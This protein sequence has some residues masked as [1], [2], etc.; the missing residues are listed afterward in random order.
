MYLQTE[1]SI[2]ATSSCLKICNTF[3]LSGTII[4]DYRTIILIT[5]SEMINQTTFG[6]SG[7]QR[8]V[9]TDPSTHCGWGTFTKDNIHHNYQGDGYN[10]FHSEINRIKFHVIWLVSVFTTKAYALLQQ[11]TICELSIIN[12][13]CSFFNFHQR[14]YLHW[15]D[16]FIQTTLIH[17]KFKINCWS[18]HILFV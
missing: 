15:R 6:I 12:N 17:N 16:T 13:C 10:L 7:K 5:N 18:K 9:T 11:F 3:L 2:T 14:I 4:W 1:N 8:P